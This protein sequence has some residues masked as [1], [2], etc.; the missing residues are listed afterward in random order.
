MKKRRQADI[1]SRLQKLGKA[2][3]LGEE[4]AA[5]G[6]ADAAPAGPTPPTA[7]AAPKDQ[8]RAKESLLVL[9][10]KALQ[11]VHSCVLVSWGVRHAAGFVRRRWWE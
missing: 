2:A 3:L 7:D 8:A 4:V 9:K 1:Q 6:A 5:L 10:A 11:E